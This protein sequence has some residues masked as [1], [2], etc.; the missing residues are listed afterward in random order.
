MQKILIYDADCGVCTKLSEIAV[1]ISRNVEVKSNYDIDLVFLGINNYEE[2]NSLIF[3]NNGKIFI[4]SR[5][6]FEFMKECKNGLKIIGFIFSN[7]I[8]SIIF[9]PFYDLF[10]RNR[11]KI[12]SLLGLNACKIDKSK[13]QALKQ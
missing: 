7:K 10:A 2:L 3:V 5:A 11:T 1:K 4:K 13:H 12:S 9:N 8:S 6:V